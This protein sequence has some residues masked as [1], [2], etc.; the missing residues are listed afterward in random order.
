MDDKTAATVSLTAEVVAAYVSNNRI[1]AGDLHDLI[2]RVH[3]AFS[4]IGALPVDIVDRPTP[5]EIRN[6][7]R[8]DVLV[9]FV[10]GRP[11]KMLKRHLS[12]HGMTI[13]EYKLRY[14]LPA[15]YPTTAP[16]YSAARSAL[17]KSLNLGR[18]GRRLNPSSGKGR[19]R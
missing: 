10:D 12:K 4:S 17:A 2:K 9:S 6:S 16:L 7:I 18:I 19:G 5:A 8:P 1:A 13:E 15:D 14:G 3:A 11:Y